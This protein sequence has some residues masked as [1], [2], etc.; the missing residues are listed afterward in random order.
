MPLK[1]QAA[2]KGKKRLA[3]AAVMTVVRAEMAVGS[4]VVSLS[5]LSVAMTA[6]VVL[7]PASAGR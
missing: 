1:K 3:V 5:V 6:A 4:D 7:K 2:M